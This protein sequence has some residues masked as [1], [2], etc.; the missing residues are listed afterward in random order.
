M[1]FGKSGFKISG[2]IGIIIL[3]LGIT[4]LFGTY[5]MSRVSNEIVMIT[6]AYEPLQNILNDIK[7]HQSNQMDSFEKIKSMPTNSKEARGATEE[8]LSSSII[9]K[10]AIQQ[11][12]KLTETSYN[13]SP[14]E[15]IGNNFR[16]IHQMFLDIESSHAEFEEMA[17]NSIGSELNDSFLLERLA[18][19]E[20]Q[21][22]SKANSALVEIKRFDDQSINSIEDYERDWLLVQIG[23]IL[24]VGIIAIFLRRFFNQINNDLKNEVDEK[25][26]E[27]QIA[28]EK[29]QELDK[30]KNEFISIASHELKSPIQPIFGYAELAQAGD[31]DQKEAWEGVTALAKKLQDLATDVLD[32]TR[33]ESNRL[34]LYP[35]RFSINEL[36]LETT[37]MLNAGLGNEVK[38]LTELDENVEIE[39]DRT[40]IEQVLR[41]LLSNAIKF[42]K[43]GTITTKTKI[44]K[45]AGEV[46][47]TVTDT[48]L[49]IPRD[50]LPDIFGKFVTKGHHQE[51]KSG[52]G[53]GL[54]LCKGIINAHG[55][56]ISAHNNKEGGAT[57]EFSLPLILKTVSFTN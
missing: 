20:Q 7:F 1:L 52:N 25:T 27:L 15:S 53:L 12:K 38:M 48:G 29:L 5:Q 18:S 22:V 34:T 44:D 41:N 14:T 28:N 31:I 51:N 4:I 11:G 57:F 2:A 55:G 21:V 43:K 24:I 32:V 54:F 19:R 40:R 23:I 46:I 17:K 49:G 50:I 13:V 35:E 39:A 9:V 26:R 56:K 10:S 47:V 6:Q 30:R 3:L 37:K 16:L 33:I 8:F 42:T 36:I 45:K